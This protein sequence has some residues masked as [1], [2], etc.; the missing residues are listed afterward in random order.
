M[1][2]VTGSVTCVCASTVEQDCDIGV[3]LV[4]KSLCTSTPVPW[5]VFH[6]HVH[7]GHHLLH[8]VLRGT[9][10][11]QSVNVHFSGSLSVCTLFKS[12]FF[13]LT[14][15]I[16]DTTGK[17]NLFSR[18]HQPPFTFDELQRVPAVANIT[19]NASLLE[20]L[21][22]SRVTCTKDAPNQST[23]TPLT[24]LMSARPLGERVKGM[25]MIMPPLITSSWHT[26]QRWATG[27]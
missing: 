20:G 27:C 18:R 8:T 9:R 16:S 10:Y 24:R 5:M 23:R 15:L 11:R 4:Q 13:R 25:M 19:A 3:V 12:I 7:K 21:P 26:S 2:V 17:C 6:I 14:G 1:Q 22:H